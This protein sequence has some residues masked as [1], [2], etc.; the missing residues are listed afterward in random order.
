MEKGITKGADTYSSHSQ[1][2]DH[3]PSSQTGGLGQDAGQTTDVLAGFC[4]CE[5]GD[6]V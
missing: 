5:G 2:L 3:S 4:L 6:E 1:I